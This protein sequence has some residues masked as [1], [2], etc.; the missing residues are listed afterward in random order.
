MHSIY[1]AHK[2]I[3]MKETKKLCATST[4]HYIRDKTFADMQEV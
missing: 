4:I 2:L 1:V 3:Q